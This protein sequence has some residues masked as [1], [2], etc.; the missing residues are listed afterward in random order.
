MGW[1][2]VVFALGGLMLLLAIL[3][4]FAFPLYESPRY[5]LGREHDE[6]AVAVVQK[7]ARY[8]GTQS[9]LTVEDLKEAAR[10]AEQKEGAYQWRVLSDNSAWKANHV[11]ALFSTKKMAWSTSLLIWIWGM[12]YVSR[13]AWY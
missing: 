13:G 11:R 8:N 12:Y 9:S 1:R 6:A 7:I 10:S 4:T 3:R 5:L 2:Y